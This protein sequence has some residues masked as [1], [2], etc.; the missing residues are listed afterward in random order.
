MPPPSRDN[1]APDPARRGSR[2]FSCASSTCSFPSR[3]RAR[4]AKMSR[5]SWVR[6]MT[7]RRTASSICRSCAGVSSASKMTT[8]ASVSAHDA[9]S[10]TTFP[11]PRKVE[12]SAF[13]RS[14]STRRTT[15]AP[16]ASARPPSSS[17]DRSAS[18]R[19]ARPAINPTSAARSCRDATRFVMRTPGPIAL[20]RSGHRAA[21]TGSDGRQSCRISD[22]FLTRAPESRPRES[23][24]RARAPARCRWHRRSSTADR[25]A[26]CRR[27]PARRCGRR[28][29][30]RPR[31]GSP[32]ARAP[33][34]LALVAVSGTAARAAQRDVPPA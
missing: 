22:A 24:P 29:C 8:S 18:S 20:D 10:V 17:S 13:G 19:F 9:A 5:M 26:S 27:R 4:R 16:A 12:G 28:A 7:F 2:Y 1:A 3:V 34:R 11:A 21:T 15:V 6:S 33:L 30:A 25:R 23:L 31:R 32:T 14:C